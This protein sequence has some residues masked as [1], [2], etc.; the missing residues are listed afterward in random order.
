MLADWSGH[1]RLLRLSIFH[2]T[3]R[4]GKRPSWISDWLQFASR[5]SECKIHTHALH[6]DEP[7]HLAALAMVSGL[8]RQHGFSWMGKQPTHN[9]SLPTHHTPIHT[10]DIQHHT[11]HR[12]QH[13]THTF[14]H[15]THN[16]QH[17]RHNTSVSH[18]PIRSTPL[19]LLSSSPL[20]TQAWALATE[21]RLPGFTR[22]LFPTQLHNIFVAIIRRFRPSSAL[23]GSRVGSS[24]ASSSSCLRR[25]ATRLSR[26]LLCYE[27]TKLSSLKRTQV[28]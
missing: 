8:A 24:S 20:L 27:E 4:G 1:S 3:S 19:T 10:Q 2:F 28:D 21:P 11:P 6:G 26:H 22:P 13:T 17:I 16:T 18:I 5:S 15:R 9:T 23:N 14:Y 25:E 12:T 7:R